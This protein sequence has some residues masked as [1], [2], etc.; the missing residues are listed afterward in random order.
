M[1]KTPPMRWVSVHLR[2]GRRRHLPLRGNRSDRTAPRPVLHRSIRP[3]GQ[4]VQPHRLD[5]SPPR[6]PPTRR[7]TLATPQSPARSGTAAPSSS[8]P[9]HLD[10]TDARLG[11]DDQPADAGAG[12]ALTRGPGGQ[13]AGTVGAETAVVV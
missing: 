4:W 12:R 11:V 5:P 6:A 2:T 8:H 13:R 7:G 1:Y 10:L 9:H 3:L